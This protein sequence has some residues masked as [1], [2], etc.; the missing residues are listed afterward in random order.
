MIKLEDVKKFNEITGVKNTRAN[1][2]NTKSLLSELTNF[3]STEYSK[4]EYINLEKYLNSNNDIVLKDF[5]SK[6]GKRILILKNDGRELQINFEDVKYSIINLKSKS[7]I[8]RFGYKA[9]E[10]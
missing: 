5:I 8:N 2:K 3:K 10:Y 1:I 6:K 9:L 4:D 7:I